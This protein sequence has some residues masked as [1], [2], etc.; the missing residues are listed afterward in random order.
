MDRGTD[1]H[2]DRGTE[3]QRDRCTEGQ[4]DIGIET[5]RLEGAGRNGLGTDSDLLQQSN[6]ETDNC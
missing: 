2:R 3:G 1:G 4:R 5:P 6:K